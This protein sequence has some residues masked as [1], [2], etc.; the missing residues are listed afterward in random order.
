S[1]RSGAGSWYG[2]TARFHNGCGTTGIP[3]ADRGPPRGR[4]PRSTAP[5]G[6]S[7]RSVDGGELRGLGGPGQRRRRRLRVDDRGDEVEPTGA[8][9]T[10]VPGRGVAG[11]LGGELR[12]LQ[13]D[14]RRH[15]LGRV[16]GGQVEHRVV[17]RVEAGQGD[18][19]ERV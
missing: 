18:E 13:A 15:A 14:V 5:R 4:H 6:G 12:L 1:R 2:R 7:R 9:L 3:A 8:D 11:G 19:L 17:Q 16:A 10:L